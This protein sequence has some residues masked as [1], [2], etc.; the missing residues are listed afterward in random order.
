M[1]VVLFCGGRGMRLRDYAE[2]V[3]KPLV[4]IGYRPILWHVMKYYAHFGHTD[5]ILCLGYK[6][7]AIK[8]YFLDYEEAIS[9][10]FVMSDGGKTVTL[11]QSDIKD[12]RITFVDT[13]MNANLAQR[14][15]AIEPLVRDEPAFFV[16][17]ADG[18]TDLPLAD[19]LADFRARKKVASFLCAK[20]N[21]TYEIVTMEGREIKAI[22]NIQQSGFR[23]NGGYFI[24]TPAIFEY[25]RNGEELVEEPFH[26]LVEAKQLVAYPYD[27]FW[28]PMDTF[29]EKEVLD[30][31][32]ASGRAPWVVWGGPLRNGV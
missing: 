30:D 25:M 29:K 13:G 2:S 15:K 11:L 23:I 26:R 22:Q 14:L 4:P 31:L 18:L 24:F 27:G 16:N 19:Q 9:N 10:D 20:P 21:L 8:R 28:L 32:F 12:W 6:G 17:Y 1:K 5:F 7:D 3:P